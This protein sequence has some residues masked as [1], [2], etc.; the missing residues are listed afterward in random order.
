MMPPRRIQLSRRKGA[1]LPDGAIYAAR[2]SVLGNPFRSDRFGHARAVGL[3]RA[4]LA[5]RLGE[6]TLRSLGFNEN[7]RVA[8]ERMRQRALRRIAEIGG[9]DVGCFCPLTSRWC[10]VNTVIKLAN[11][12]G[13]ARAHG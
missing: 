9:Q 12:G 8:L 2:P 5:G 7:E 1:R 3:H 6:R 10:H 4:W 11:A 13:E